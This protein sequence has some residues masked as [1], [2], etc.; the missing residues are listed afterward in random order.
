MSFGRKPR[1]QLDLVGN[2]RT[3]DDLTFE[4]LRVWVHHQG[5]VDT[6]LDPTLLKEPEAFGTMMATVLHDASRA[7]AEE[8]RLDGSVALNRIYQ[9]MMKHLTDPEG[10]AAE[11]RVRILGHE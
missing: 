6:F 11:S 7:Y 9:G 8:Y 5:P 4:V 10:S 1:N 3:L 2:D